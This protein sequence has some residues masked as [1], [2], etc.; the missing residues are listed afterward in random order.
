MK[1]LQYSIEDYRNFVLGYKETRDREKKR[2]FEAKIKQIKEDFRVELNH[3]SPERIKLAKLKNKLFEK[4]SK[5]F[6]FG[7]DEDKKKKRLK[8]IEE[9]KFDIDYQNQKIKEIEEN[10]IYK[11]AFEWRFEFPEVL[12][13]EGNFLGFDIVI[14]NPPYGFRNILTPKEKLYFRKVKNYEFSSGDSAELFVKVCFNLLIKDK[15]ILSFII[16]KKSLYGDAWEDLR[17]NY[18]KKYELI[19]LL[20][21]GKS[22]EGILLEATAFCLRKSE[23]NNRNV[24]LAF[25]DTE[26]V[27]I[28]S[29]VPFEKFFV[30]SNT[31]QI[32]KVLYPESI[33]DKILKLS[34]DESV[35]K[36]KLGLAIGTNFFSDEPTD[37]KLLKGIDIQKYLVR[38]NRYLKNKENLNWNNAKEFL[39][40]KVITQVIVAHIENPFP[41]LKI[42]ACYDEEGII[43][44]NTLMAFDLSEKINPK[45]W[46]AYLNTKFLSWYAYNFIY[47]GAI[48]TMHFYDFYIQ[49]IPIPEITLEEQKPFIKLVDE[50]L[51][52]KKL[53]QE[54]KDLE[55]E[56][57]KLVYRLYD[58]TDEEIAIVE[59]KA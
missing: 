10:V 4:E 21:A 49:Q 20:D 48:R 55:N 19:S 52:K 41:H 50:I 11:N 5:Q 47:S 15:S 46:L 34:F 57:D 2:E 59:G 8:R 54:T 35:V 36:G 7:E 27:K 14:G 16:P 44:T 45:F 23:T 32:Y 12:D 38:S 13:N 56:I 22:F 31:C 17:V 29:E 6:L 30:K 53:G 51:E 1:T 24:E 28:F 3:F 43:I 25:L 9:L 39:N 18:W 37:Y 58:L 33:F 42:T 26:K 40:P